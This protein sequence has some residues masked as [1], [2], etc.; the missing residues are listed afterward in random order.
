MLFRSLEA[1]NTAATQRLE[2]LQRQL[3]EQTLQTQTAEQ[4]RDEQAARV[5]ALEAEEAKRPDHRVVLAEALQR[6]RDLS[7]ATD[8]AG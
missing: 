1:E 3:A 6:L 5:M 4:A 2:A 8:S 7:G